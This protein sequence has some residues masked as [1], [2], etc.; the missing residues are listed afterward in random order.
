MEEQASDT[1]TLG[2]HTLTLCRP[3]HQVRG[4]S[5]REGKPPSY[6]MA[7]PEIPLRALLPSK[8]IKYYRSRERMWASKE[9]EP[10]YVCC[11]HLLFSQVEELKSKIQELTA[12]FTKA[13][14]ALLKTQ[15]TKCQ[16]RV[17][18]NVSGCLR[19]SFQEMPGLC[20]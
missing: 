9:G 2:G 8:S 3:W 13:R 5:L 17:F 18:I 12:A 16:V 7:K 6:Q 1:L 10:S 11:C 14:E 15:V 4:L 19:S 20:N